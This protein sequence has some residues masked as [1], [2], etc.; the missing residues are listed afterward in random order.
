MVFL[1]VND[2]LNIKLIFGLDYFFTSNMHV[3]YF[4]MKI[5]YSLLHSIGSIQLNVT[6]Y[7]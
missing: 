4:F 1:R 5:L 7:F 6:I 3:Y 2:V